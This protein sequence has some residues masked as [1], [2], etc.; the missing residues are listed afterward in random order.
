MSHQF[1]LCCSLSNLYN[2]FN[3]HWHCWFIFSFQNHSGFQWADSLLSVGFAVLSFKD[4]VFFSS[5]RASLLCLN[6][7][8]VFVD[9]YNF[10]FIFP[11]TKMPPQ[12]VSFFPFCIVFF[13][14]VILMKRFN[15]WWL[16]RYLT[17]CSGSHHHWLAIW[18]R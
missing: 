18:Y 7:L 11:L 2:S 3:L 8:W 14:N 4:L 12:T 10:L 9:A 15:M 16:A 5:K 13:V 1:P 6:H 17:S